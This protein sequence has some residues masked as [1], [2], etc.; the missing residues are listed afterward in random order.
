MYSQYHWTLLTRCRFGLDIAMVRRLRLWSLRACGKWRGE[1]RRFRRE[2]A[3][4]PGTR[5]RTRRGPAVGRRVDCRLA[6]GGLSERGCGCA[7]PGC[8]SEENGLLLRMTG[9]AMTDDRSHGQ[10]ER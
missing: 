1:V 2:C 4:R 7:G 6:V 3:D 8:C 10:Q 9:H 5:P